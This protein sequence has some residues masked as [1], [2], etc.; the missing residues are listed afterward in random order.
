MSTVRAT[1][2][3]THAS[4]G[5]E[6]LDWQERLLT[7][8]AAAARHVAEHAA[9]LTQPDG[10]ATALTSLMVHRN[11]RLDQHA[12]KGSTV[13]STRGTEGRDPPDRELAGARTLPG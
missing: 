13:S 6:E 3:L 2:V 8:A 10:P 11:D 1:T 4:P 5:E 7:L 12:Q 9:P